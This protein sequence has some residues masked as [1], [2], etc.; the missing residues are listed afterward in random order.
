MKT[1]QIAPNSADCKVI[2]NEIIGSMNGRTLVYAIPFDV[3]IY[4]YQREYLIHS[5]C[6]AIALSSK[7]WQVEKLLNDHFGVNGKFYEK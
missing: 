2:G 4:S 6:E 1:I 7:Q 3:E 5:F